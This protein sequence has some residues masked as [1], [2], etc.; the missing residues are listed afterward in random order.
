MTLLNLKEIRFKKLV[1]LMVDYKFA[2]IPFLEMFRADSKYI[3]ID[4]LMKL[5][6]EIEDNEDY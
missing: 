1:N 5:L 3:T 6:D 4:S 2:D